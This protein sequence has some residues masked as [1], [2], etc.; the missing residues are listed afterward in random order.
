MS[1]ISEGKSVLAGTFFLNGHPIV[2]LFDTGAT[3]DFISNA[4]TQRYQLAIEPTN[5]PY[6]ISTLGGRVVTKKLVMYTPLNLTGKLF[7]TSLIVL[8]GQGIDVIL[9]MS[10]MKGQKALF[11]KKKEQS[12]K[13]CVD[14]RPLNV[15]IIKN[16]YHLSRIDILF[17]QLIGAKVFS[18]VDLHLG[19]H[20]IKICLKDVP[21]TALSTRYGLYEYLI[22]SFGLTNAPSQFMYRMN[23]VFMPKLDEIVMVFIDNILI[24]CKSKEEHTQHLQVIWQWLCNHQLYAKFSKCAFWMKDVPFL[25]HVISAEGIAVDLSKV[26]VVLH[27]K[28][29]RSIMQ[30]RSFLRLVG[31]YHQ[32]I[33]NFSKIIKPMTKHLE[34]DAKFKWNL[35]CEE[36]F[37]TL[38]KLLT[39]APMLAQPDIEKSIDVYYDASDTG[40]GGVLMQDDRTITYVS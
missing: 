19:Y 37:L 33:P 26:Q 11:V 35:Q 39:T 18:K 31:Y 20:Q 21:K 4:C 36:T 29:S 7:R 3:Y 15:V 12:L 2:V 10:W 34:K 1:D 38:K 23:T 9:G 5:T 6:V 24:Y 30:I 32:F 40:I 27:W 28:S 8:D 13:L 22:M 16:K 25:G 14:Y 17:Y